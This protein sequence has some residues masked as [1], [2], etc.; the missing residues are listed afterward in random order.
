MSIEVDRYR[1]ITYEQGCGK[2]F[3][4]VSH[5]M[6]QCRLKV[7]KLNRE[8]GAYNAFI[9]KCKRTPEDQD[10]ADTSKNPSKWSSR[11]DNATN[12]NQQRTFMSEENSTT[13]EREF[14]ES[15]RNSE[16]TANESARKNRE[17]EEQ[18]AAAER[19]KLRLDLEQQERNKQRERQKIPFQEAIIGGD[20]WSD[21]AGCS[22]RAAAV[23]CMAKS[24]CGTDR[25]R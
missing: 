24:T 12:R 9:A 7:D 3:M 21:L 8:I 6:G 4:A 1:D 23:Q 18:Q 5:E 10:S 19:E 16:R 14:K 20:P 11:L 2:N 22:N 25:N 13:F 17:M 15:I